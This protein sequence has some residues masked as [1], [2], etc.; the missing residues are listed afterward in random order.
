[1]DMTTQIFAFRKFAKAPIKFADTLC[2]H[3]GGMHQYL[4][5]FKTY[6]MKDKMAD[7]MTLQ[8]GPRNW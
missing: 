8:R 4:V 3:A 7:H 5:Q 2:F 1:M 6:E